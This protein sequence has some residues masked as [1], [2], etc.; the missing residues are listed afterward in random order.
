MAAILGERERVV[1]LRQ[2]HGEG[3]QFDEAVHA[4]VDLL[5]FSGCPR[6]QDFIR[7]KV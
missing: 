3:C 7:T 5:L 2:A 1:P 4:N 6:F